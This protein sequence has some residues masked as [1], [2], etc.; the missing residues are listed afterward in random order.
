MTEQAKA[1]VK[2]A[3]PVSDDDVLSTLSA[4][5]ARRWLR[6]RVSPGRFWHARR[7]MAY[8][9]IIIFALVPHLRI[10]GQPVL[11]LDVVQRRFTIF[12]VTF[13]PTDTALIALLIITMA[14][15]VFFVTALFGRIWCGWACPQTVYMEFLFRPVE[16][17]FDGAP[18][19]RQRVKGSQGLRRV[20]KHATFVILALF[21]AHTFL[22]YF[23]PPAQ[24][25]QWMTRSPFEHPTAFLVMAATTGLMLFDFGYF[26]EQT[27]LIACPYGRFQAA[28]LD[29]HSMIITYDER[30]G[31][32]RG[33]KRK[34]LRNQ[35]VALPV[36]EQELGDCIDC[37]LC[38][39]TCPTGIDIR[40]GLQME[41][42]GCAQCI[43]ACDAVMNKIKRPRGLIRY[44]SLAGVQGKKRRIIRPRLI[45]YAAVMLVLLL[46]F[47]LLLT[48][49]TAAEV[50]ILPRQGSPFYTLDTGEIGNQVRMRLVNRSNEVVTYTVSTME[51]DVRL[52]LAWD[53]LT[54][55]PAQAETVGLVAVFPAQSFGP[56]GMREVML[57]ITGDDGFERQVRYRALGPV[58]RGTSP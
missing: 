13:L 39:T 45:V 57:T 27:C 6:P 41:C 10:N 52:D 40:N 44:S 18:G 32:P 23:V 26:R 49:R 37:H 29:R 2:G 21:L 53:S 12:G 46:L 5:G 33:K 3:A 51:P 48:S 17:F 20:L 7:I 16:R 8:L 42:I 55:E 47:A 58:Q 56:R 30:R 38:V 1:K 25:I 43:D 15:V 31:E 4:D 24:L 50:A 54:L 28:M 19:K 14:L 11:L 36:V 9:L 34:T 22:A 35:D